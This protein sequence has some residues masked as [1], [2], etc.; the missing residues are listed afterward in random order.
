VRKDGSALV[1]SFTGLAVYKLLENYFI[2]LVDYGFTS[3]MEQALDDDRS[4]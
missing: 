3:E 2:N 1:P 4:R